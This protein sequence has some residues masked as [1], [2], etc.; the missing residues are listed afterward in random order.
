MLRRLKAALP[1]IFM[2]T[3][4]YSLDNWVFGLP[5]VGV[6]AWHGGWTAFAILTPLYF[7]V[8]YALGRMTLRLVV[9]EKEAQHYGLPMRLVRRW[10][11]SLR[12]AIPAIENR[13]SGRKRLWLRVTGFT[14]ASYFGTAFLTVPAMYILGQRRF[15][16]L[17]TAASAAIYAVSFVAQY[18]VGTSIVLWLINLM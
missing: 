7:I 15:L 1:V 3:A 8:D 16:R 18:T 9:E 13:L 5:V 6:T 10:F 4:V 14:V 11:N 2:M 12:E 17:L